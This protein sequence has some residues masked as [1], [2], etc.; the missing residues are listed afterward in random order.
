MRVGAA[1]LKKS[2]ANAL[3]IDL[4]ACLSI[5]RDAL[6]S[7]PIIDRALAKREVVVRIQS[8]SPTAPMAY[9][10]TGDSV[11][12]VTSMAIGLAVSVTNSLDYTTSEAIG[13]EPIH[14]GRVSKVIVP[15]LKSATLRAA[16]MG[17]PEVRAQRLA[18]KKR[19]IDFARSLGRE[20]LAKSLEHEGVEVKS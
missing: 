15:A 2:R 20:G 10:V 17:D 8:S 6:D 13:G 4:E 9:L 14:K 1:E 5:T 19:V 11:T 16:R 18:A 7:D 3:Q 12:D